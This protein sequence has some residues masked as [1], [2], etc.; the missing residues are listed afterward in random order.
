MP[1]QKICIPFLLK[2]TLRKKKNLFNIKRWIKKKK[3]K[4]STPSEVNP[5][6]KK[7]QKLSKSQ[8]M[9]SPSSLSEKDMQ[10]AM[11][12][13]NEAAMFLAGKVISAL[14]RNSNFV[15]SPASINTVV[16]MMTPGSD[17]HNA[18]FSEIA[19]LVFAD[20][21]TKGGPKISVIN[22]IWVEQSLPFDSSLKDLLEKFFKATFAQVD[23][24]FKAGQVRRELNKWA[25]DHS[26]GL[27]RDLLPPGS[28]KSETVQVYGNALYFKGAWENKFDKSL[29]KGNKFHLLDGKQVRVPFMRS[30][31]SQY[32]KAYDGFKVLGLPYQ[33]GH[34]DTKRKF[35][36]YFYLPDKNDGLDSLLKEMV[37]TPGFVDSHIPRYKVEVADFRIPKFNISF[38]FFTLDFPE[39]DSLS[40]YHKACVEID[41]DGAKAAAVT[42]GMKE[43]GTGFHME[44]MIDF[45]ADH[46]FLF[47]IRED[48]TGTILFH[49]QIFDPSRK[50]N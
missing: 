50:S 17:E 49:G 21:S 44:K 32:I 24:R 8:V 38:M 34:D 3:Q 12:K 43:T 36:M 6:Q 41:E 46:P 42:F 5:E 40:L 30:Y 23:F 33:Q 4:L 45:V 31:K 27:I 9:A 19:T 35:S 48:K 25:S 18:V 15:F 7:K 37:S 22:R 14:D 16:T 47:L 28:V 11:K 1:Y 10:E 13:Q 39:L 26:N 20:G 29:T 2:P